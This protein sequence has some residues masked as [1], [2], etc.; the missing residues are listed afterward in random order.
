[1]RNKTLTFSIAIAILLAGCNSAQTDPNPQEQFA[2]AVA[3][4]APA[5]DGRV[6]ALVETGKH[7]TGDAAPLHRVSIQ[8][9]GGTG[10]ENDQVVW[11]SQVSR[12]PTIIWSGPNALLITQDPYLVSGVRA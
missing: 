1:V 11:E 8:A 6:I 9:P 12:A 7:K 4:R 10:M 5:P 2:W 3:K